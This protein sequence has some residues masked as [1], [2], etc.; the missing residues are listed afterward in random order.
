MN[1]KTSKLWHIVLVLIV[2]STFFWFL[3]TIRASAYAVPPLPDGNMVLNPWFRDNENPTLSGLDGWTDAAGKDKYWSSSQKESNPSPEIIKS[4]VCGNEPVYCGTGARL[5]VI[6]G[7]SGGTAVPGVDANLYQVISADPSLRK[8]KFFTYWVSHR[9]EIAEVVI[10]GSSTPNG[11]WTLLWVPFS[12]SNDEASSEPDLWEST[13]VEEIT[14]TSGYSYYKI[15]VH[16][17]L[18]GGKQTGFKITG[19][20]FT[21][22]PTDGSPKPTPVPTKVINPPSFRGFEIYLPLIVSDP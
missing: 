12:H 14:L 21:T 10:L 3:N 13:E 5:S 1:G 9:V 4:G 20:Y 11:P 17:R 8:L 22:I 6:P 19:I 2:S 18:P 16:A 7:Q 15:L